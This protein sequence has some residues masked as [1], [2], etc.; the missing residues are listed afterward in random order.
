MGRK[1]MTEAKEL[2][3]SRKLMLRFNPDIMNLTP[4]THWKE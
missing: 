2:E 4:N 3:V 1:T